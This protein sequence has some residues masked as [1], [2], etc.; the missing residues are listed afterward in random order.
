[1]KT[2]DELVLGWTPEEKEML[3]DL[4]DECRERE[5][6]LIENSRFCKENLVKLTQSLSFLFSGL[7]NLRRRFLNW[8]RTYGEFTSID[9]I[10]TCHPR[11]FLFVLDLRPGAFGTKKP[12]VQIR[13]PRPIL[14]VISISWALRRL[15]RN[16][17]WVR[18]QPD[19]SAWTERVGLN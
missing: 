18:M 19:C 6:I 12:A 4:I 17:F 5:K 9:I 1:M 2:V 3:K 14:F 7:M 10:R 16:V 11:D 13:S 15:K 8:Q